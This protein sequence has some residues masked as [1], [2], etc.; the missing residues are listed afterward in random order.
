MT[1]RRGGDLVR[2]CVLCILLLVLAACSGPGG[3]SPTTPPP[4]PSLASP[5]TTGSVSATA[6]SSSD[7]LG[8]SWTTYQSSELGIS[9]SYPPGWALSNGANGAFTLQSFPL[10]PIG[11]EGVP[12]GGIKVDFMPGLGGAPISGQ[13]FQVGA[14][15]YVGTLSY[16]PRRHR[17]WAHDRDPIRSI[18]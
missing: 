16:G 14:D 10:E 13:P 3:H 9:L 6:S 2:R 17:G 4:S 8:E 5:V 11:H 18:E 12:D 15:H 1:S 7:T